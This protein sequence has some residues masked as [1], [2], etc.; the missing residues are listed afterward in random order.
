MQRGLVIFFV[1]LLAFAV[2]TPTTARA[3]VKVAINV[4]SQTMDVYVGGQLARRWRVSTGRSGFSTPGG[5]Y[6]VTRTEKRWY[7]RKYGN[8][9][10]PNAVF[11]S[12]G[13]AIHGTT[14]V[15]NLGRRASHGCVRLHP[16][17]AAE[18]YSLVAYYGR[19]RTR[20]SIRN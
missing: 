19:S 12:G 20:I 2:A 5:S 17:N 16:S 15:G 9:P 13:Y 7:S 3:G 14:E 1:S 10:M 11:F 6:G 8:A 18:L 4:K